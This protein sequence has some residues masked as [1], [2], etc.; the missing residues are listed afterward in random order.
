MH[1]LNVGNEVMVMEENNIIHSYRSKST[2]AISF[3]LTGLMEAQIGL[4]VQVT[5]DQGITARTD[6]VV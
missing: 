3:M 2:S 6:S 1:S 5:D 4:L